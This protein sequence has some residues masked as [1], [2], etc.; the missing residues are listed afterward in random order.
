MYNQPCLTLTE[1]RADALVRLCA[2]VPKKMWCTD[3]RGFQSL[4]FGLNSSPTSSGLYRSPNSDKCAGLFEFT[5]GLA[6]DAQFGQGA[7]RGFGFKC[8]QVRIRKNCF[9]DPPPLAHRARV[10][11]P[12]LYMMFGK[13]ENDTGDIM[14]KP[15]GHLDQRV[16]NVKNR[17]VLLSEADS[18]ELLGQRPE[19]YCWVPENM[20]RYDITFM[21]PCL[22]NV[23]VAFYFSFW[24]LGLTDLGATE[25]SPSNV[26][27]D[28]QVSPYSDN[29]SSAFGMCVSRFSSLSLFIHLSTWVW[30]SW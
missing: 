10:A 19:N 28:F 17:L 11:P 24:C 27:A 30:R 2:G 3:P 25:T 4:V 23:S 12:I 1:Y 16:I 18:R 22:R 21:T 6:A 20:K 7:L 15:H 13:H 8:C 5:K 14:V 9:N 29:I 26:S